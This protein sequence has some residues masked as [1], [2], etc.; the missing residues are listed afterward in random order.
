M[1]PDKAAE[2]LTEEIIQELR[3]TILKRVRMAIGVGAN[4]GREEVLNTMKINKCKPILQ[5]TKQGQVLR[6]WESITAAEKA[7]KIS[8]GNISGCL[9]PHKQPPRHTA[10]GFKWKFTKD[11]CAPIALSRAVFQKW[12]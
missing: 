11:S 5:L 6:E 12:V 7:L 4:L 8:T 3:P 9:N 1:D 2:K 10:G